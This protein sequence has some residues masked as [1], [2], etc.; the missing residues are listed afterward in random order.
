MFW[1][2]LQIASHFSLGGNA[3]R[4]GGAASCASKIVL[5]ST[6]RRKSL[7]IHKS[8]AKSQFR[9]LSSLIN[10]V[11]DDPLMSDVPAIFGHCPPEILMDGRCPSHSMDSTHDEV[12]GNGQVCSDLVSDNKMTDTDHCLDQDNSSMPSNEGMTED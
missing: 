9:T 11:Q 4:G 3:N 8:T 2:I 10:N 1:K 12:D 7:T 5:P 6:S